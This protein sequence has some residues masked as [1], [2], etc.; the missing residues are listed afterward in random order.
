M[1]ELYA[2]KTILE[3]EY[4]GAHFQSRPNPS[5]EMRVELKSPTLA[6]EL[7]AIVSYCDKDRQ[8]FLNVESQSQANP[9]GPCIEKKLG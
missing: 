9:S 1:T 5:M 4:I 2:E 6:M 8:V 7:L 3:K